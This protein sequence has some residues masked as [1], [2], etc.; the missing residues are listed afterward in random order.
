MRLAVETRGVGR[1]I[2]CLPWFSLDRSV[3]AAAL[4]PAMA[5]LAG[6]QRIYVDL[7]GCG[8]SPPGPADSD[9]VVEVLA[10]FLDRQ[11]GS[12]RS[13]LAGCSYGGYLA[14]ALARRYPQRFAGLLLACHGTKI[15]IEDRDLPPGAGEA[16]GWLDGVP[17][18]L[19]DHLSMAIGNRR[20][21]VAERIAAVLSAARQGNADYLQ[22]LR[23]TGYQLSDEASTAVFTG[24]TLVV[25][26][27]ED[28]IAG[29]ADQFRS[30]ASYPQATFAAIGSA[31][32][33]LPFEFPKVFASLV[34]EWLHQCSTSM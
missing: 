32:H 24:P 13:L 5:D 21:E 9:G 10:D 31:G 27:R 2:V 4:E 17:V 16:G 1:P 19:R 3:M 7:P 8:Q 23:T 6:W 33:Y 30:L 18:D 34:R 15:R 12:A 29:Y 25:A 28:R 20:P 11:I 14:A 26:G 22:R